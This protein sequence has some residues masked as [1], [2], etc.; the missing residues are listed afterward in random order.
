M[1]SPEV[2]AHLTGVLNGVTD[3]KALGEITWRHNPL[4][5]LATFHSCCCN[6][7]SQLSLRLDRI[8]CSLV[9]PRYLIHSSVQLSKDSCRVPPPIFFRL[10][11]DSLTNIEPTI[12]IGHA[13]GLCFR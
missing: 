13:L 4:G 5:L 8:S 1:G 7:S 3:A 11:L 2:Q 9:V 10:C 12:S 6:R